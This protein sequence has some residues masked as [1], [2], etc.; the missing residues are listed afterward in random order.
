MGY[1]P[2]FF[3]HKRK[4]PR[5]KLRENAELDHGIYLAEVIVRP[6][7]ATHSGRITVYVP[8]LSKDRSDPQG[9]F[10]CYWSSPFA[11]TTPSARAACVALLASSM[12]A[13]RSFISVSVA[14]PTLISAT[15]PAIFASRS[16]NFSR[17]YSLVVASISDR[18]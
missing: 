10:N 3:A 13:L 18:I 1:K 5:D 8:M 7:D 12:R 11:G 4:N 14:A 6:K 16:C 2:D 9:Y 17:S 15:P